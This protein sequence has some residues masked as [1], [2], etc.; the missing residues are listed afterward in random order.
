ML[1]NLALSLAFSP[2][3]PSVLEEPWRDSSPRGPE[4][5]R[6]VQRRHRSL[7]PNRIWTLEFPGALQQRLKSNTALDWAR[8]ILI[9]ILFAC[10]HIDLLLRLCRLQ[11]VCLWQSLPKTQWKL[12]WLCFPFQLQARARG[13]ARSRGKLLALCTLQLLFWSC[14][15]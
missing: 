8:A 11:K 9:M 10:C 13:I 15:P 2:R 7:W 4:P 3:V 14:D 1:Q 12:L 6:A 5:L